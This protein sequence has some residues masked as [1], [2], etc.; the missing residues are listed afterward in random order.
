MVEGRAFARKRLT[1]KAQSKGLRNPMHT[2]LLRT[3]CTRHPLRM[4]ALHRIG[5]LYAPQPLIS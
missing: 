3:L 5:G 1:Q 2:G 4:S